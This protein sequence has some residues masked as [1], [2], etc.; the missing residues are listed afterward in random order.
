MG[1]RCCRY[2]GAKSNLTIDHVVPLSKGGK[3]VWENLVTACGR[4]NGKKG[5]RSLKQL[6]WKLK[7]TPRVRPVSPFAN[8][9]F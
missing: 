2:C 7:S 1:A 4:C 3:W 6:G 8:S 9:S 5:S